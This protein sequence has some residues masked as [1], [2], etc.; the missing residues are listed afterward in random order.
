M[1]CFINRQIF[2]SEDH[3][4][5]VVQ[6]QEHY[7]DIYLIPYP[8]FCQKKLE[9]PIECLNSLHPEGRRTRTEV[10]NWII[11]NLSYE[12]LLESGW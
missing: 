5:L 6:Y 12:Q 11:N 9:L 4:N 1:V 7:E 10:I 2:E 3:R 8:E